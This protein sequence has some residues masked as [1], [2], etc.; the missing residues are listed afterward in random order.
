MLLQHRQDLVEPVGAD[1][2]GGTTRAGV[3]GDIDQGLE[4][5][6][7]GTGAFAGHDRGHAGRPSVAEEQLTGVAHLR[8]SLGL[9][10]KQPQFMGCTKAV[11]DGPEQPMTREAIPFEGEH[12][13]HE[14][15]EH[16]RAGQHPLLG[17]VTHQQQRC[18]LTLGQPLQSRRTF[19]HLTHRPGGTGEVRVMER[20]DAVD[21]RHGRPQGLQ[22]LQDQLQIGFSQQL[23]V[24]GP[25]TR[26]PLPAQLHLLS[27]FLS[28]D[29]EHGAVAGHGRSALEQQ[30][31]LADAWV[32]SHQHQRSGH[33]S[34]AEDTI[35]FPRTGLQPLQGLIIQ[36]RH[37]RGPTGH[38]P[39]IRVRGD[40]TTTA[41]CGRL[42][43]L[44]Q[45]I[46][47]AA[48][49]A[50]TKKLPSFRST[51]LTDKDGGGF[52]HCEL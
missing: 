48:F 52:G 26:Q 22:F 15:L 10:L 3:A 40:A 42:R 4:V 12:R 28:T 27:R 32:A 44:N 36:G 38:R 31:A 20:L 18:G 41:I 13:I 34:T 17:D 14:V 5:H 29:V 39:L 23:Q 47:A 30:G 24:G 37:R 19:P 2:C 11:F 6:H 50:A 51:A 49:R 45:R 16:L 1:A 33:Q 35:K 21:D 7:Q 9:H 46:P 8:Q 25:C 43:L